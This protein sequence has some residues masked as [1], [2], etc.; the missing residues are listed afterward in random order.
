TVALSYSVTDADGSVAAV[1]GTLTITFDDDA[2]TAT[3]EPAGSLAEGTTL[4]GSFDFAPGADGATV[5]AING[6]ALVFQPDG[7]SQSIDVGDAAIRVKADG[8]YIV[9]ADPAVVGV[10]SASGTFT[11]TD[12]DGDTAT[13]NFSFSIT[14]ANVPT[15]GAS[16]ASVDD[17]GLGGNAAST[18]GD[19]D[20]NSGD[21]DGPA[22]SEASFSGILTHNF[23]GDGA[24]T[25]S[26]ASLHGT[27]GTVG[28]EAVTYSWNAG[29]NTLTATG[30]RGAL[31]SVHVTNPATGAYTVTLLDNVLQAQGPN[32]E[33][34]ATVALSYSV[35]DTDGSVAAVPGTLTIT[36]DDDAPTLTVSDTPTTAIEGG[37]AVNGNWSLAP[38][39]DGVAS[40]AVTFGAASGTLTLPAGA[41]VVLVQPTGTLTVRA[42]GTF[43]FLAATGQDNDL[44]PQATFTLTA[45][46]GD[47]DTSAD[48]LTIAIQDGTPAGN[49]APVTLLVDE[50]ALSFGSNSGSTAEIDNAPALS[51][52]AGS[53]ALTTFRFSTDLSNLVANL[54]GAGTDLFWTRSGDGQTIIGSL[55]SGGPAAITLSLS[56]PA[57]IAAGATGNVT[58]TVTL[59]DNLPHQLALAAQTQSIGHAIVEALD[60]DG[61]TATGQVFV[62]VKDDVPT[63]I[64]DTDSVTEDGPT[65]ATGN[66]ITA[67][68]V[69]V[70][71][72]ANVT[73]GTA[74]I[75]GADGVTV[76]G[77]AAGTPASAS[78]NVG[79]GVA[80]TY[81]TLTLN[82]NGSYGYVLN[83]ASPLVQGLDTGESVTDTFTYTI[84]DG[85]GD[86][87]TTTLTV[88]VNGAN[89]APVTL[90]SHTWM[91]SDPAQQTASTPTYAN[92]YPIDV[93]IP[94]D[95]DVENLIVTSTNAP[96]GVFYFDG[97][98][99]I[100]LAA[101]TVLYNPNLGI[102]LLDD[103]VYRPTATA[104]DVVTV[105]L[106]LSVTDGTATVNQVVTI[107]EVAPTRLPGQNVQ[108]GSDAGSPLTSGNDVTNSF[109][110]NADFAAGLAGNAGIAVINVFTDFQQQPNAVP[111]PSGE[112]DPTTFGANNAG[113]HREQEVQVE[114]RI[115][116]NRFVIVEDDLTA[117]TF[118]QSWFY[119]SATGLMRATVSYNNV[120]LLDGSGN[121]TATTLAQFLTANP[122]Q[123][124]D[125]WTVSY[126][127]NDGGNYQARLARFEF[128][129][130]DAGNP[131]INVQGDTTLPDLI[132]GTSGNDTLAGN[133]GNDTII[134]RG[135]NDQISGGDGNDLLNGN[136]GDDVING[137]AGDDT[138]NGGPGTDTLDGGTGT[139]IVVPPIVLDLDGDGVELVSRDAGVMFDYDGDGNAEATAWAGPD[140]GF[141][142]Y[143]SNGD[144]LVTNGSELVLT[145]HAAGATTDLEALA[146]AFDTNHDGVLSAA[147]ADFGKFGV[148]QDANGNGITD[149]GE[150]RTLSEAGIVSLSLTSDGNAR[151]AANG[152]AVVY[153]ETQYVRSDGS[154]GIAADAAFATGGS[155]REDQKAAS[156][157]ANPGFGQA[158][159]A[160]GLVAAQAANATPPTPPQPGTDMVGDD[161]AA[162]ADAPARPDATASDAPRGDTFE[163]AADDHH[164]AT[165]AAS[166]RTTH[167]SETDGQG[168][169]GGLRNDG[170]TARADDAPAGDTAQDGA[171]APTPAPVFVDMAPMPAIAAAALAAA[172][173]HGDA[174]Q[175]ALGEIV[176]DALTGGSGPD[177]D[178]LLANLPGNADGGSNVVAL[179]GG[180]AAELAM[181]GW[182]N[183]NPHTD[184]VA[185]A[186][187]AAMAVTH[188]VAAH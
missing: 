162:G 55:T 48:S 110:L 15:A 42:D 186:H 122:A 107:H 37:P 62:D 54:D 53:D 144:R 175:P 133:G 24:G 46:D 71:P 77:V 134:G 171:D 65:T 73:D 174:P 84:T 85:D 49:A 22:S 61:D 114:L 83:N 115:G 17:D 163:I 60:N 154:T 146:I 95:V 23:G 29:T 173:A 132:Y 127:D 141:L 101:N 102:N 91:S 8:S 67:I 7:Y 21:A 178:A 16:A 142:V 70:S 6:T 69:L 153:G 79:I 40:L 172:A 30:S 52:T 5:T 59:A 139:N 167:S 66:V 39:A 78:G 147:D 32:N 185:A 99:Y 36:F 96:V 12:G 118:E 50:A 28:Q 152:D 80:G 112:R 177:I 100:P 20:A 97:A 137:N 34:D 128:S 176:A 181:A 145:S 63:A 182:A 25:I 158:L 149:A 164:T 120:Y 151:T 98:N 92:G 81:G 140:D 159:V 43:S 168:H 64:A 165:P 93:Q 125:T 135:G 9:T 184:P 13:A 138:L 26:F 148:W 121:A 4:P 187:E 104:N 10:G 31:F 143:D 179:F 116:S 113:S 129:Y 86:V 157:F 56:A 131:A 58:V 1:P 150:F 119:D 188:A 2:P 111:I 166:T 90:N 169:D 76:T 14:D 170:A 124:G 130:N 82:A 75:Q 57:S 44:S 117:G 105:P 126:F 41:N 161:G 108:I 180:P 27:G 3:N 89:D 87:S 45:T 109:A 183:A 72:D 160:A 68:D 103:L 33:N 11:V 88:T 35:T 38:G 74:D 106:N 18:I 136:D 156:A 47:G 155:N 19:L 51:F 123:A 94:T